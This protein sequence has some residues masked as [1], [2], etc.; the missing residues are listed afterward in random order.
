MFFLC[1]GSIQTV[2][3]IPV[4]GVYQIP[5]G[6]FTCFPLG[7]G[8]SLEGSQTFT[9]N[10]CVVPV[11]KGVISKENG[12]YPPVCEPILTPFNQTSVFQST[13]PKCNKIFWP[14]Q[15]D[16]MLKVVLYQS[17]FLA[18]T[19]FIT[20]DKLDSTAKGTKI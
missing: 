11:I 7:C 10:C 1:T 8:P 17:S 4:T 14:F 6:F 20:P 18:P 5:S 3:Q 2:C 16:S 12:V 15:L 19:S 9:V 13:A